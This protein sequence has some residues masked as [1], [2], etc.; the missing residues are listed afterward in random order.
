MFGLICLSLATTTVNAQCQIHGLVFFFFPFVLISV[1]KWIQEKRSIKDLQNK[2]TSYSGFCCADVFYNLLEEKKN[3]KD[4]SWASSGFIILS[5]F[6]S[7]CFEYQLIPMIVLCLQ[8]PEGLNSSHSTV[9]LEAGVTLIKDLAWGGIGFFRQ[10]E[11]SNSSLHFQSMSRGT[12]G[13]SFSKQSEVFACPYSRLAH[14]PKHKLVA[15][16]LEIWHF[17]ELPFAWELIIKHSFSFKKNNNNKKVDKKIKPSLLVTL[18]AAFCQGLRYMPKYILFR[19]S[20]GCT[21]AFSVTWLYYSDCFHLT[22]LWDAVL[23]WQRNLYAGRVHEL[24]LAS[25]SLP[26]VFLNILVC[27]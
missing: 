24:T 23:L 27:M 11:G 17:A 21:I 15:S 1:L 22:C 10:P 20:A 16:Q 7:F 19:I 18:E 25:W 13:N 3:G 26:Y 14:N 2:R 4:S 8:R 5:S 9:S 12:S 6:F